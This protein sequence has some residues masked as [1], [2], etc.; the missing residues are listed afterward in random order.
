MIRLYYYPANASFTPHVLL[1]EIGVPFELIRVDKENRSHKSPEYLALNPAG[2]IPVLI[3]GDLVLFE[4][5]A[6]CLHLCDRHPEASLAPRLATTERAHFYKWLMFFTNTIQADVL[7][8]YYPDRY[9]TDRDGLDAVTAAAERRLDDWFGI[10][11]TALARGPFLLGDTYSAVDPYLVMLARWGRHMANPP[12][13][14]PRIGDLATRVL[15]RP[16]VGR[17]IHGEG[18]E[19]PFLG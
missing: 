13:R 2:R 18:L 5:A 1:E 4:T 3:D 7:A 9:T 16:A 14:R 11:E 15:A 6:I 12:G 17:A 8:Y 19:G 10:V